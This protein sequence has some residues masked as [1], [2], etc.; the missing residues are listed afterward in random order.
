[1]ARTTIRSCSRIG[2]ASSSHETRYGVT[3]L[4]TSFSSPLQLPSHPQALF[5]PAI[6]FQSG[7]DFG[8]SCREFEKPR[9]PVARE[10][11]FTS[12]GSELGAYVSS[13]IPNPT[14]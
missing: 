1:M 11:D 2:S 8:L 12:D 5:N 9:I 14:P 10:A 13:L 4:S 3:L 7:E 6:V